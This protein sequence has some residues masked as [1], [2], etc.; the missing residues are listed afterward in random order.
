MIKY[1]EKI[2]ED[3]NPQGKI[4]I[5]NGHLETLKKITNDYKIVDIEKA[6]G[7]VLAVVSRSEGKPIKIGD[8]TFVPGEAIKKKIEK[9]TTDNDVK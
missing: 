1:E 8:D 4:E 6:L 7:F 5:D 3:G 9:N 2:K